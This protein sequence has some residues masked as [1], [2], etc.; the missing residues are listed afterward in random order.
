MEKTVTANKEDLNNTQNLRIYGIILAVETVLILVL[1]VAVIIVKVTFLAS[2]NTAQNLNLDICRHGT[3]DEILNLVENVTKEEAMVVVEDVHTL[4]GC[5]S[6]KFMSENF[7]LRSDEY[8]QELLYSYEDVA[9]LPSIADENGLMRIGA[10]SVDDFMIDEITDSYAVVSVNPSKVACGELDKYGS[11]ISCYRGISFN[12]SYFDYQKKIFNNLS[13]DFVEL[14]LKVVAFI[15]EDWHRD[16]LY[17]Y[18][19]EDTGDKY[20]LTTIYFGLGT[21]LESIQG[22][23]STDDLSYAI[24]IYERKLLVDKATGEM[25]REKYDS[26]FGEES[27]MHNL[28]SIPLSIYDVIEVDGLMSGLSD[29]EIEKLKAQYRDEDDMTDEEKLEARVLAICG[30]DYLEIYRSSDNAGI[31]KCNDDTKAIYAITNPDST[32]EGHKYKALAAFLGTN[33]DEIVNE[34]FGDDLYI[35]QNYLYSELPVRLILLMESP[36]EGALIEDNLD[37]IYGYVKKMNEEYETDLGLYIYYTEDLGKTSDLKDYI[38]MSYV[39][40]LYPWMPH[41]NGFGNYYYQEDEENAVLAEIAA[42]P[43][44]YSSQTRDAIKFHRHIHVNIDNGKDITKE[45]LKQL[46]YSSF[47]N[48]L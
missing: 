30:D 45:G 44:L 13:A 36:S 2:G 1:L 7:E 16:S 32:E 5:V 29:E 28:R 3:K 23:S 46:L 17:D 33:D 24:N 34:F 12:K 43:E 48:G 21:D 35:Y 37:A 11:T 42:N 9:E 19:F 18:Y 26:V 39:E 25:T 27:L 31:F 41:G 6:P 20:V 47:E 22:A 38:I 8:R 4:V 10:E 15:T 14:A 40:G